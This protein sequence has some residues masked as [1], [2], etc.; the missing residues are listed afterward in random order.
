MP[1]P[2]PVIHVV[3]RESGTEKEIAVEDLSASALPA[4]FDVETTLQIDG[5]DWRVVAADPPDAAGYRRTGRLVLLLERLGNE[6]LLSPDTI[7]YS[8]PTICDQVPAIVP[9]S[10]K[11]GL[12][13]F[14][15][16][17]DDWRQIELVA[18]RYAADVQVPLAEVTRIYRE[19]SVPAGPVLGFREIH[20]RKAMNFPIGDPLTLDAVYACFDPAPAF[21]DGVGYR[22]HDGLV[23]GGFAF[24][25][26][27]LTVYGQ[28]LDGQVRV[29]GLALTPGLPA[30][31]QAVLPSV[32]RLMTTHDLLLV[33]W[34]RATV[35][36]GDAAAL[37]QYLELFL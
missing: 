30:T 19:A 15:I 37:Q 5:Q 31:A 34:C 9:E 20:V 18:A 16:L 28:H 24:A 13:T 22:G 11:R 3:L 8:L 7:L 32:A 1:D 17:E 26:G 21:Y 2:A 6:T 35:V 23:V 14:D 12:E 29:L 10:S 4:R 25:A 27:P 33:D 36:P